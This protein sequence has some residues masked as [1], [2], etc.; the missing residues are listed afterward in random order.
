[1]MERDSTR[2]LPRLETKGLSLC[3]SSL[4]LVTVARPENLQSSADLFLTPRQLGVNLPLEYTLFSAGD[5]HLFFCTSHCYSEL[6]R[7]H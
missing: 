4:S 6:D 1:M 7:G 2:G 3:Q 5:K